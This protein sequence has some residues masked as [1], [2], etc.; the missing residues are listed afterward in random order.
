MHNAKRETES[1][2]HPSMEAM[3]RDTESGENVPNDAREL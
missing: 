3:P 2:K 1:G